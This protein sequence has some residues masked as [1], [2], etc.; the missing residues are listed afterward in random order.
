M[1][2]AEE[3]YTLQGEL[4]TTLIARDWAPCLGRS[5]VGGDSHGQGKVAQNRHHGAKTTPLR[6]ALHVRI[7]LIQSRAVY[8]HACDGCLVNATPQLLG[9]LSPNP[10]SDRA[11]H[12]PQRQIE[13]ESMRNEIQHTD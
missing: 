11:V 9:I 1:N 4:R 2:L 6:H 8:G 3:H 7:G 5:K 12:T 13:R 10:S